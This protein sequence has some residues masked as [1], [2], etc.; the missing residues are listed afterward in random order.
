MVE[1]KDFVAGAELGARL[2]TP[3]QID[4]SLAALARVGIREGW[5]VDAGMRDL[6]SEPSAEPSEPGARRLQELDR[7]LREMVE[8]AAPDALRALLRVVASGG[9]LEMQGPR[10]GADVPIRAWMHL[11]DGADS[12]QV[13]AGGYTCAAV[14]LELATQWSVHA[15]QLGQVSIGS[16]VERFV[17]AFPL[18]SLRMWR[19]AF[20]Q[21]HGLP[22]L[23]TAGTALVDELGRAYAALELAK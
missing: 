6:C 23:A 8:L 19:K 1:R 15:R 13:Q 17:P 3:Q 7:L 18:E 21:L 10:A 9:T 5:I 4:S 14:L 2:R 16:L 11:G 12:L 20:E 22:A